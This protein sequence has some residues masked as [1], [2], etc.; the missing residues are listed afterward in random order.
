MDTQLRAANTSCLRSDRFWLCELRVSQHFYTFYGPFVQAM[1]TQLGATSTVDPDDSPRSCSMNNLCQR[2]KS[3]RKENV[4]Q[5]Q[6]CSMP[7]RGSGNASPCR[8]CPDLHRRTTGPAWSS[9]SQKAGLGRA[10]RSKSSRSRATP[11]TKSPANDW[12]IRSRHG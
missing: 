4:R 9:T 12:R 5:P 7:R 10:W 1:D 6:L 2:N 11:I 3:D 8:V